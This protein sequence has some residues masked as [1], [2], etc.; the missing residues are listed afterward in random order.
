MISDVRGFVEKEFNCAEDA[1]EALTKLVAGD[2]YRR[3]CSITFNLSERMMRTV[4]NEEDGDF[5][6][7]MA[8]WKFLEG[9]HVELT[10]RL[11]RD[12]LQERLKK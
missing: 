9:L 11:P 6:T 10:T 12:N 5:R 8:V 7:G 4:L 1:R 2:D 3:E